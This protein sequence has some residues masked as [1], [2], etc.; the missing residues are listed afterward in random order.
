MSR[1]VRLLMFALWL[2]AGDLPAAAA[3][4][5]VDPQVEMVITA[6]VGE[7]VE[8]LD[9][10]DAAHRR[11][12]AEAAGLGDD[13]VRELAAVASALE[14]EP[15]GVEEVVAPERLVYQ[16]GTGDEPAQ[17]QGTITLADRGGKTE[18]T[19]RT[20]F[21]TAADRD[22][23]VRE[24]GAIAGLSS[25]IL[26][27]MIGQPRIFYAMSKDGLLPP[28]FGKVHPKYQTPHI[29]TVITGVIAAIERP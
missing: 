23:A 26:V 10:A 7:V 9:V 11:R 1:S 15:L 18:L 6:R 13:P 27:M 20:L 22:F 28:V 29:N 16:H 24:V 25:V 3:V 17:F 12:G 4:Q 5:F 19:L 21:P 8:A 14:S 2:P